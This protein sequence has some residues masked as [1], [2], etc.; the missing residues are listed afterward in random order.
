M[1]KISIKVVSRFLGSRLGLPI[2]AAAVIPFSQMSALPTPPPVT[3][4]HTTGF[5]PNG[6]LASPDGTSLYVAATGAGLQSWFLVYNTEFGTLT[7]A[8]LLTG[9]FGASQIATTPDGSLIFV[10]NSLTDT[11][12]IIDQATNTV[13]QTLAPPT[14]GPIPLGVRTNKKGTELWIANVGPAFNTGT[15]QVI[16]LENKNL[17][18]PIRL[19]N[20]GGAPNTVVFN[21]KGTFAFI[22]NFGFTG[23]VSEVNSKTFA[24]KSNDLAF[25]SLNQPPPLGMDILKNGKGL[26]IDNTRAYL[27]FV[28][29]STGIVQDL[30]LMTPGTPVGLD[31]LGQ[32]AVSPD[33]KIVVTAAIDIGGIGVA[34]VATNATPAPTPFALE[35]IGGVHPHPYFLSW[36]KT[37]LY[38]SLWN[39][40]PFGTGG[41]LDHIQVIQES[42]LP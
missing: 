9:Q 13:L 36:Y 2:L 41:G 19:I 39:G 11:V 22:L 1:K 18:E 32:V 42:Q 38:V 29:I 34:D 6:V 16:S 40:T 14:I 23:F 25:F 31:H 8:L 10:V 30:I 3:D 15:V 7:S 4:I 27:N 5:N 20:T 35:V 17:G 33:Q 37:T 12:S 21:H 24:F 26:Y 28:N